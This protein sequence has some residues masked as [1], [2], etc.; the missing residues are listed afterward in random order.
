MDL[1]LL[2]YYLF[3]I[4][5]TLI[6]CY[7]W[8]LILIQHN[9]CLVTLTAQIS[10][11]KT[12]H[13]EELAS[14]WPAA[15]TSSN[16]RRLVASRRH[17]CATAT[18]IAAMDPTRNWHSVRTRRATTVSLLAPPPGA[19]SP[20]RGSAIPIS[21]VE[22][23]RIRFSYSILLIIIWKTWFKWHQVQSNSNNSEEK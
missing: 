8:T 18:V 4:Y 17:G 2:N 1:V 7:Y 19:A 13:R 6:Y 11:T 12:R 23:V 15:A 5:W 3:N 16:A 14:T 20:R 10:R 9:C 22:R 21:I